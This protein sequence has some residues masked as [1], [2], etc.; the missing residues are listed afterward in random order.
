MNN[1]WY[2]ENAAKN[3]SLKL[4]ISMLLQLIVTKG[5]TGQTSLNYLSPQPVHIL[6]M[7]SASLTRVSRQS[8]LRP[9]AVSTSTLPLQGDSSWTETW[10]VSGERG[11]NHSLMA[12]CIYSK[13][14][15]HPHPW[16]QVLHSPPNL[17]ASGKRGERNAEL[18]LEPA[19][20]RAGTSPGRVSEDWTWFINYITYSH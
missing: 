11:C 9:V 12:K 15:P 20:R 7:S 14:L 5:L 18:T 6:L 10:P 2:S 3:P 13:A 4:N 1:N 8:V 16:G 17:L 19:V